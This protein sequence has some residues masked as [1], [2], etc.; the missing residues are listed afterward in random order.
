MKTYPLKGTLLIGLVCGLLYVPMVSLFAPYA[1]TV[2]AVKLSIWICLG[3]YACYLAPRKLRL[4]FPMMVSFGLLFPDL[5]LLAFGVLNLMILA[6]IRSGICF[7]GSFIG[8]GAAELVLNS[9]AAGM[10]W[11]FAPAA[12]LGQALGVWLFF[13]I[14]SLY[15]LFF[16]DCPQTGYTEYTTRYTT[17]YTDGKAD[18]FEK[19]RRGVEEILAS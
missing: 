1:G 11:Y 5:S 12:L 10:I 2:F 9:A 13:L 6:W 3:L 17:G 7:P 15:F 18:P 4:F 14:Q 19:A 16:T 8:K